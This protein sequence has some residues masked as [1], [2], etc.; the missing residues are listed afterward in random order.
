MDEFGEVAVAGDEQ[1]MR[2]NVL[3]VVE[4]F[5]R[6]QNDADV[7]GVLAAFAVD[8]DQFHAHAEQLALSGGGFGPVGIGAAHDHAPDLRGVLKD[9]IPVHVGAFAERFLHA[10]FDV[11]VVNKNGYLGFLSHKTPNSFRS[12]RREY[13]IGAKFCGKINPCPN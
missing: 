7:G 4:E 12:V 3:F 11:V 2:K 10:D 8:V 13:S 9:A 1:D 5:H 6:I